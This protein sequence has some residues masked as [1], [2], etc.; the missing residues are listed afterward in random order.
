MANGRL[1]HH[2]AP[3][4][5]EDGWVGGSLSGLGGEARGGEELERVSAPYEP[6]GSELHGRSRLA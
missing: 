5:G 4:F 3:F 6:I 2:V 1:L